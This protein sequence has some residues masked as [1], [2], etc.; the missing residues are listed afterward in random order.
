VQYPHHLPRPEGAS[1]QRR[2]LAVSG[3]FAAGDLLDQPLGFFGERFGFLHDVIN[4]IL[5]IV[6]DGGVSR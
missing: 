4:P 1:C 6:A 5:A 3:H 2:D